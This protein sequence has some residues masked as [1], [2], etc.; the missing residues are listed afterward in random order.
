MAAL[1]N[2]QLCALAQDGD[3]QAKNQLIANNLPFVQQTA[4]KLVAEPYQQE[5]F[6]S[7][8]I[9][10]DDLVQAGAIGLWRAIDSYD[11]ANGNK[12]LTYAAP[13]IRRAMLDLI[14]QYS[15]DAMWRLRSDQTQPQ[16][17]VYLDKP[18]D[19]SN[20]EE[21]VGDLIASLY[22]TLPEQILI[23]QETMAELHEAMDALSE[24]E[25]MYVRH[26]FGFDDDGH[27]L[28]ETAG[29]FHLS[30]SRAKTLERTALKELRHELLFTIPG[31]TI[32]KAEDRLTKLLVDKD[33]L[34]SVELRLKSQKKR[35]KKVTAAV[36]EYLADCGGKW[37]EL[38]YNF[39]DNTAEVLLL[40]EWDTMVSRRFAVRAVEYLREH[41]KDVL[42]ERIMLT[43]IG[44]EQRGSYRED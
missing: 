13:A 9:A 25:N 11:P 37:G 17:I 20:G 28:V 2:E 40:A 23:E 32:T 18:L 34:H 42:P 38:S 21:T 24:R 26:R 8:G 7:C 39:K 15:R 22:A 16:Q 31:R 3:I 35:S 12:F 30:E 27:S 1:S 6:A 41:S 33:E 19:D 10:T 36:Y 4:N 44:P 5:Q 29:H 14:E 43:F